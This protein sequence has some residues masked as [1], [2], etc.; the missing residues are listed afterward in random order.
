MLFSRGK[1]L[2]LTCVF[3]IFNCFFG[4]FFWIIK[5]IRRS[6]FN[7]FL[8]FSSPVNNSRRFK[9]LP[10]YIA[11]IFYIC[12]N[13]VFIRNIASGDSICIILISGPVL[14]F[15][16]VVIIRSHSTSP[17]PSMLNIINGTKD[18]LRVIGS[19]LISRIKTISTSNDSTENDYKLMLEKYDA[20]ADHRIGAM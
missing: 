13:N 9:N 16:T 20:L 2:D 1:F 11:L 6:L 12:T 19:M 10:R 17:T 5:I 3:Y 7:F 14:L 18:N 4:D 8:Y 15:F